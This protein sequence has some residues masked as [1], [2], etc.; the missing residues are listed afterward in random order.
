MGGFMFDLRGLAGVIALGATILLASPSQAQSGA[1]VTVDLFNGSSCSKSSL[2]GEALS[3]S[4]THEA[5]NGRGEGFAS[6]NATNNLGKLGV[7]VSATGN[8]FERLGF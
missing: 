4:C 2:M 5:A 1:T 6:A 3:T 7:A 8:T